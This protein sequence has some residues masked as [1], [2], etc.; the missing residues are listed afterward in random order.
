MPFSSNPATF[1][2]ALE[3]GTETLSRGA[4]VARHVAL[5][6]A[7]LEHLLHL[8]ETFCREERRDVRAVLG[9]GAAAFVHFRQMRADVFLR[10][11]KAC[12]IIVGFSLSL[13]DSRS[14]RE[15]EP[16]V[17][18]FLVKKLESGSYQAV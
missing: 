2:K 4:A 17:T 13:I 3:R 1:R 12:S 9:Q 14:K 10:A 11:T 18:V 6:V 8:L 15:I 7:R 5:E 16:S